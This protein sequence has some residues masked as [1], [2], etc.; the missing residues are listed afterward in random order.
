[1]ELKLRVAIQGGQGAFHDIAARKYFKGVGI[2]IVPCDTFFDLFESL[3]KK[4]AEAA[5]VA[6]ENSVAGS[7]IPNYAL[8]THFDTQVTGMDD[9][10]S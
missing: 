4:N 10:R 2:E 6:I 9:I 5:V 1:M 3:A 8:L 7:I